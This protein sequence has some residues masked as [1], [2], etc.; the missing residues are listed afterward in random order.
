M[1]FRI[2]AIDP[3]A[4]LEWDYEIDYH[5]ADVNPLTTAGLII[6]NS[7]NA[8]ISQV[9][10]SNKQDVPVSVSSIANTLT[11]TTHSVSLPTTSTATI[12]SATRVGPTAI[13]LN[14][15]QNMRQNTA[16]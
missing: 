15:I 6:E 10:V 2:L 11:T 1:R 8:D 3:N 9:E 12:A 14:S 16:S 4:P 13:L 5:P 7:M